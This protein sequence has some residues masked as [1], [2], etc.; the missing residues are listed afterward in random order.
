[1]THLVQMADTPFPDLLM[2]LCNDVLHP[3][4]SIKL[5]R[6]MK[7][8]VCFRNETGNFK[9]LYIFNLVTVFFIMISIYT[10]NFIGI[11]CNVYCIQLI[12]SIDLF[13]RETL[14]WFSRIPFLKI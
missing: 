5:F 2:M 11:V 3:F 9:L 4:Q 12:A 1:M 8:P 7:L 10:I 14:H 6:T 13:F